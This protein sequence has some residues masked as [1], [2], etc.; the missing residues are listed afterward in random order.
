MQKKEV[1]AFNRSMSQVPLLIVEGGGILPQETI[2]AAVE[3]EI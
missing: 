2:D 1:L 3:A